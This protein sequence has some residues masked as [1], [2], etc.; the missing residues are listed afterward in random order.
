MR[1]ESPMSKKLQA[2]DII[3]RYLGIRD[4][5]EW[6]LRQR[7]R[8][9]DYSEE[10][11]EEGIQYAMD[12]RWMMDPEE[13]SLRVQKN[14]NEKGK[15][16]QYIKNFLRSKRLPEVPKDEEV[17]YQKCKRLVD[18]KFRW[19]PP[20]SFEQKK[21]ILQYLRNRT[22]DEASIRMVINEGE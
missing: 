3:A 11:I 20:F 12:H 5:S 4:Y 22:Y 14:L 8:E 17:E 16:H 2:I 1:Y 10:E 13:L 21:K 19:E 6:E 7:L 9:K 15:S 18:K